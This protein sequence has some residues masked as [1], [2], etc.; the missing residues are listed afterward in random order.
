MTNLS[1]SHPENTPALTRLWNRGHGADRL[2]L[3]I[4]RA[5]LEI[6]YRFSILLVQ[7][8]GL[9]RVTDRLGHASTDSVWRRVL[10]VLTHDLGA[11]DLCCRLGGEEFMLIFPHQTG[12]ECRVLV[13][14]LRQRWTSA[15]SP[16]ETTMR[17]S[18][19]I[20]SYPDQGSTIEA[21][22]GAGDEAMFA[23]KNKD[24]TERSNESFSRLQ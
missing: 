20:A 21:M 14:R 5:Q 8:D 11:E 13:D 3:E 19:G 12:L 18:V 1:V 7:F 24:D 22:F 15:R 23:D 10:G 9:D 6:G 16:L 4:A 2:G 17:L